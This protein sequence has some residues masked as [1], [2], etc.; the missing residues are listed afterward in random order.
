MIFTI[1]SDIILFGCSIAHLK[2][3]QVEVSIVCQVFLH[4]KFVLGNSA[5]SHSNVYGLSK[6][7]ILIYLVCVGF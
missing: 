6:E 3:F 4:L 5:V 7:S 1:S 2:G